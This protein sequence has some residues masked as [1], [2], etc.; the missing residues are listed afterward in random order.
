M[1]QISSVIMNHMH[2][3]IML[4]LILAHTM[5][6]QT[7]AYAIFIFI[8]NLSTISINKIATTSRLQCQLLLIST[9]TE[10]C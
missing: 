5:I 8:L 1:N 3:K 7:L 10:P 2:V 4:K 6:F 9:L